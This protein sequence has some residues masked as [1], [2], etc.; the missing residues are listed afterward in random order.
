MKHGKLFVLYIGKIK[1][2]FHTDFC[3]GENDFPTKLIFNL[4]EFKENKNW[5]AIVKEGEG[6]LF[7]D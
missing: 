3:G 5:K 1:P 7:D 6:S 2:D 4:K